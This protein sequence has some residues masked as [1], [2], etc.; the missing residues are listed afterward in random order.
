MAHRGWCDFRCQKFYFLEEHDALGGLE[1]VGTMLDKAR[2][3]TS[4][5]VN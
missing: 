2:Y 5:P 1:R 4:F 3:S